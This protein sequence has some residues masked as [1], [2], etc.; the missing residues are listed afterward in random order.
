MGVPIVLT[1]TG[2]MA[3]AVRPIP[4]K[5]ISIT[6]GS[7]KG[8]KMFS[9]EW[10]DKLRRYTDLTE[11]VIKPNPMNAKDA[12][13]AMSHEGAR[14]LKSLTPG[15]ILVVLDE[16]GKEF[17]S[18][19]VAKLIARASDESWKGITFA[20]G[21]PYGHPQEVRDQAQYVVRL[22]SCVLNHSVAYVVLLE[23]LYRGW[24]IL[25]G[26]PYHH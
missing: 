22:S 19:D 26:E 1:V 6:K 21:G 2:S 10:A 11:I 4:M 23:Q 15:E 8:G 16:R 9:A 20:I 25:K 14:V 12:S 3:R 7:S 17:N 24:T 18:E 5:I 13:V